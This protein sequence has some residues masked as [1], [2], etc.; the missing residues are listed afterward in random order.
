VS[1]TT[2]YYPRIRVD[3]AARGVVSQA[4]GALL[5]AAIRTSGLDRALSA[6]LAR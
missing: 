4:G 2:G 1:K 3:G 5:T 6:A